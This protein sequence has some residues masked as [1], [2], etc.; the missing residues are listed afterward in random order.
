MKKKTIDLLAF[1]FNDVESYQEAEAKLRAQVITEHAEQEQKFRLEVEKALLNYEKVEA[2]VKGDL[3]KAQLTLA[4]MAA[5]QGMTPEDLSRSN[6]EQSLIAIEAAKKDA[7]DKIERARIQWETT[8]GINA[9][10]R[11]KEKAHELNER[12]GQNNS[13]KKSGRPPATSSEPGIDTKESKRKFG[14]TPPDN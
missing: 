14:F 6:Y 13:G 11:A 1:M 5:V 2:E 9:R 12:L 10:L 4:Q 3:L 8:H 7:L